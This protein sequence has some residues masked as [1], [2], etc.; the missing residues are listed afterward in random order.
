MPQ[1]KNEE[2]ISQ[3]IGIY[4]FVIFS[5]ESLSR[6]GCKPGPAE[7]DAEL[8]SAF[9][10]PLSA[11]AAPGRRSWRRRFISHLT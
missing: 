1:D 3:K 9:A 6:L 4:N 5:L 11:D 10:P 8:D 2:F 7:P